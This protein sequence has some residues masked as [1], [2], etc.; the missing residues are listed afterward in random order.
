MK[1]EEARHQVAGGE[2]DGVAKDDVGGPV[3][4]GDDAEGTGEGGEDDG[5]VTSGF[6]GGAAVE[7]EAGVLRADQAGAGG[8]DGGVAAVKRGEAVG[9]VAVFGVGGVF[10]T[11]AGVGAGAAREAFG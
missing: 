5:V 1:V 7:G 2:A 3:V 6:V 4:V 11:A 10:G 9:L 8:A